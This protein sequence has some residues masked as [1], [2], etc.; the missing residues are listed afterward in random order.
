MYEVVAAQGIYYIRI[1]DEKNNVVVTQKLVV[2]RWL[3]FT[4]FSF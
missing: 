2:E 4:G 1:L 3:K